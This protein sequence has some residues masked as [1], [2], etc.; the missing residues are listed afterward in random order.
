[1]A[2]VTLEEMTEGDQSAPC[3][4]RGAY[5]DCREGP[6]EDKGSSDSYAP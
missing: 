5:R 4:A 3:A 1:M 6:Y 2:L